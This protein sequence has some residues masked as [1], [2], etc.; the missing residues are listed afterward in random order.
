MWRSLCPTVVGEELR[1]PFGT[2]VLLG[3]FIGDFWERDQAIGLNWVRGLG[4]DTGL[5]LLLFLLYICV[6]CLVPFCLMEPLGWCAVA[7][8][9]ELC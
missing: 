6:C 9:C 4:G 7:H 2:G 3:A 5:F 8:S 1:F